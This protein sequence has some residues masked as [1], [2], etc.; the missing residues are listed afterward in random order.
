MEFGSR[1]ERQLRLSEEV[2]DLAQDIIMDPR[3]LVM[4]TFMQHGNTSVFEH[5]LSVAR[6]TLFL[7]DVLE[8]LHIKVDRRSM[9]RAAVLHD[10]FLYDWHQKNEYHNFHGF[11]HPAR[12]L[13]NASRDFRLND[14]ERDAIRKHMFPLTIV[15][16]TKRESW[17]LCLSDKWCALCETFKRDISSDI[18]LYIRSR[19]ERESLI[20]G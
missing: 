19:R 16:P 20:K 6:M 5:V 11:T 17:I 18:L 2:F 13:R 15:P 7:A 14:K 12:A 10:Y 3:A 4:L 9:V 8:K 1:E